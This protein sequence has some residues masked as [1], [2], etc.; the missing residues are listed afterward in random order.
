VLLRYR[1]DKR[2]PS[3]LVIIIIVVVVAI[4]LGILVWL[5]IKKRQGN[6]S[7]S[8][9]E[10]E[11]KVAQEKEDAIDRN[12]ASVTPKYIPPPQGI[13]TQVPSPI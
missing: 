7:S 10:N 6:S 11:T 1:D 2:G 3:T 9:S 12:T 4:A 13:P 8:S 5:I